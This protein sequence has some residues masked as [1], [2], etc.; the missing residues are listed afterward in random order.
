MHITKLFPTQLRAMTTTEINDIHELAEMRPLW[1]SLLRQT[2]RASFAQSFEFLQAAWPSL[3]DSHKLRVVMVME[4]G[5]V[6]SILP[7]A[8]TRN[9]KS[10]CGLRRIASPFDTLQMCPGPVGAAYTTSSKTLVRHVL[11]TRR[12]WDVLE[13]NVRNE[14]REAPSSWE[15][16][17]VAAGLTCPAIPV[18]QSALVS[19]SGDFETYWHERTALYRRDLLRIKAVCGSSQVAEFDRFRPA[20]ES[21][22]DADPRWDLFESCANLCQ[23]ES[24]SPKETGPQANV[25]QLVRATHET[26][27]RSGAVDLNVLF[28]DKTLVA[29]LY[30]FH[31]NGN[32][33]FVWN[34]CHKDCN[35]EEVLGLLAARVIRDSFDRGETSIDFGRGSLQFAHGA[36]TSTITESRLMHFSMHSLRGQSARLRHAL[37]QRFNHSRETLSSEEDVPVDLQ[38]R[39]DF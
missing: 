4:D 6:I 14:R 33:H 21:Y 23:S 26:A 7:L 3:S 13:L 27:C 11:R 19:L 28:F 24:V 32:L 38:A 31:L 9:G 37:Q 18:S 30:G 16:G 29:F 22:G 36:Q 25:A 17:A 10:K 2:P 39:Q 1:H 8:V 5:E 34:G 15:D 35:P 12:D 20:G